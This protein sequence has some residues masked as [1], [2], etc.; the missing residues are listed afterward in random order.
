MTVRVP[1]GSLAGNTTELQG[2]MDRRVLKT[3]VKGELVGG[4]R[5]IAPEEVLGLRWDRHRGG[6]PRA[7]KRRSGWLS[8]V[9]SGVSG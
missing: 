9:K 2:W 4:G 6:G 7:T 8:N 3:G 1:E 5:R